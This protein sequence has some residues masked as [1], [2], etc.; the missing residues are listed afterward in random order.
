MLHPQQKDQARDLPGAI[1]HCVLCT[2]ARARGVLLCLLNCI[3]DP[4]LGLATT[5]GH[6]WCCEGATAASTQQLE[7]VR[8]S[9]CGTTEM[10]AQRLLCVA[11]NVEP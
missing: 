3:S 9:L 11:R 6:Q 1:A 4:L 2:V 5:T 10:Q 7:L 8:L